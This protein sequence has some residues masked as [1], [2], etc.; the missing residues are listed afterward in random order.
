[1]DIRFCSQVANSSEE[2]AQLIVCQHVLEKFA[3][4][5]TENARFHPSN[6]SLAL[7]YKLR[8][9]KDEH[10]RLDQRITAILARDPGV[11][12]SVA[13]QRLKK[14]RLALKDAIKR[15]QSLALPDIIA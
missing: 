1:M 3:P 5:L 15:A 6:D 12:D 13:L 14:Q 7:H 2:R 8:A 4:E 9:L 10:R 11:I